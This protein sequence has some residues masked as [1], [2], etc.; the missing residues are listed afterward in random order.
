MTKATQ[1]RTVRLLDRAHP[2]NTSKPISPPATSAPKP[3]PLQA[4]IAPEPK[5]KIEKGIPISTKRLRGYSKVDDTPFRQLEVG[6]SFVF[7]GVEPK[8]AA[9]LCK[10]MQKREPNRK[11]VSRAAP[12][13]VRIWRVA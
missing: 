4:A 11:F 6:D 1:P 2:A 13:G 9:A 8:N 10:S 3:A 12:G 7:P 5:F